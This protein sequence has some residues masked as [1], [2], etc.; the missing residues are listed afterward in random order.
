MEQLTRMRAIKRYF[1]S[2]GYPPVTNSELL[3]LSEKDREEL[4]QGAAKE[5]GVEIEAKASK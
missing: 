3:A 1:G 2:E 5:L 4:A